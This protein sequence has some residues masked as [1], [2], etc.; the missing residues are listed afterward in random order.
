MGDSTEPQHP[1]SDE[2]INFSLLDYKGR[3]YELRRV[4]ARA[5][6][7]F[8]TGNGCP[9]ARQSIEKLKSLRER[10]AE[11]GVAVWMINSVAGDDRDSIEKEAQEFKENPLP[12]LIDE[13]QEIA[14]LL[15][16][17]RTAETICISTANWKVFYR[18]ALDDQL[19]EG[20][21]KPEPAEKYVETALDQ[22]LASESITR[23]STVG[24]GCLITYTAPEGHG[25]GPVCTPRKSPPCF[26]AN[27]WCAI[28]PA[29]SAPSPCRAIK[30]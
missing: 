20:A 4:D 3:Y 23:P 18:G 9:V 5:V 2:L 17:K 6:V 12:V 10:Y 8:F 15:E 21:Q 26:K 25:A 16:V 1:G 27:A 24:R 28:P 22:F 7:L 30:K 11:K 14:R 29:I 19:A 13:T